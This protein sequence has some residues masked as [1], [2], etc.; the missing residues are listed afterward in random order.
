[1]RV[2]LTL[3]YYAA[4]GLLETELAILSHD[5]VT[6]STPES[7]PFTL[8]ISPPHQR[9]D[10]SVSTDLTYSFEEYLC[11]Y[12]D[13]ENEMRNAA[14]VPTLSEIRNIMK[15][16]TLSMSRT[17]ENTISIYERKILRFIF[18]GIQEIGTWQ[19][20]SNFELYQSYK[21]SDIVNF[22]KIQRIKWAGHIVRMDVDRTTKKKSS[23][24]NQLAHG[25]KAG[26]IFDGLMA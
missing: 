6:S 25:E 24:P 4:Q 7:A 5:Q 1:M 9:E 23:K 15:S 20:R 13:D 14:P 3:P 8:L 21:E 17:D 19:R 2:I 11:I 16:E 18:G 10:V 12:S 26:Q 22:I